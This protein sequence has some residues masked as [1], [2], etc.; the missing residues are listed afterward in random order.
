MRMW[1]RNTVTRWPQFAKKQGEAQ[2]ELRFATEQ[3][4][5]FTRRT[6]PVIFYIVDIRTYIV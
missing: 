3:K 2:W 4:F 6:K 5:R 1:R